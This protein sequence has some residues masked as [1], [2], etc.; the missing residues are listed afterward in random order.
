[1]GV[2]PSA[3]SRVCG[4]EVSYKNFNVGK[5]Q[6]LPQRL[7]II[8][9]GNDTASYGLNKME[10]ASAAS[11]GDRFGYGSP[12]H[13]TAKQLFPPVGASAE[14]AVTIYPL[15]KAAGSMAAEASIAA[16]GTATAN[17]SGTIFIGGIAI[18]FAVAKDD[19]AAAVLGKIKNAIS[20]SMDVPAS[21]GTVSEGELPLTSKWSGESSN[22]ITLEA[23][24]NI[25]GVLL[26][27]TGFADG[28]LDP[29]VSPA[30]AKIG[31]VWE[32]I[33]LNCFS[34][35]KTSRLD[36]YQQFGEG[37]WNV[38]EK[39]PLLVCHGCTDDLET[40]TAITD[41]RKTDGINFLIVSVKSRELPF[42]IAAKGLINDVMTTALKNPPQGYKGLL[43][44]LHA[45]DDA[46]Q[47]NYT[48]R[49][50]SVR[51]GSSTNIKNGSVAELNDIITFWHPDSEGNYPS[52]RYVVDMVKL[53][54]IVFNVRLIME[55]DELKGAPL[56]SDDTVTTNPTAVSPKMIKT[57]FYNLADSLAL[58]AI[59]A[60]SDFT[61]K[62]MT[63]KIDS[64]N[65]KRIN[66]VFPVKISG[67]IEIS[68]TDVYFG[69]YLGGD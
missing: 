30:L 11:V 37:R 67:N 36:T 23:E 54:N 61:K 47:E 57:S 4:V 48:Q 51:K 20:G 40:R 15:V 66:V 58:K 45:A 21:A 9:L 13:L 12:L 41:A 25:P 42:V 35:D 62:N 19:T 43:T 38:L 65:P 64:E 3:V 7:A 53:Q 18:E 2:S 34:Y 39:K 33:I 14:F 44:G 5:A 22:M 27:L 10:V 26:T 8:G 16:E 1:M 59:L 52:K 46:S 32:T 28:A 49:E 24:A 69:F 31:G 50:S 63:V 56:V 6:S 55:A 29:D 68:S 17:G 60:V